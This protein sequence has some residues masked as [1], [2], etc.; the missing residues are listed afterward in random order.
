[1]CL[2]RERGTKQKKGFSFGSYPE[3]NPNNFPRLNRVAPWG[4]RDSKVIGGLQ[5]TLS[6]LPIKLVKTGLGRFEL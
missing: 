1:M 2:V 5:L 6:Y 4:S 3:P